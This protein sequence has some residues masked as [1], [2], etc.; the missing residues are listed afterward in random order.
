M[1]PARVSESSPARRVGWSRASWRRA[2]WV[3]KR[4]P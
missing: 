3:T 4:A 2:G 1:A